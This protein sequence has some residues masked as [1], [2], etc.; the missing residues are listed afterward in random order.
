M[1]G[2]IILKILE[3]VKD[4]LVDGV[5]TVEAILNAGYGASHF[6]IEKELKKIRQD[7]YEREE[8]SKNRQK[9]H[10][11]LS[12]LKKDN[13]IKNEEKEGKKFFIITKKGLEKIKQLKR[14]K[15]KSMPSK[16][17]HKEKTGKA[18]IIIFD[19]PENKRKKRDW[20]REV[21]KNMDFEMVQKSVWIGKVKIPK[22]FLDDLKMLELLDFVKI[23]EVSKTGNL[24]TIN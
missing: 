16:K 1:R 22:E 18:I 9:F 6:K 4:L 19:I 8:K 24:E 5:D 15:E 23:F 17:Y 12:K 2:D 21:L 14:I 20:I 7:K 11:I 3:G 13:L 10:N